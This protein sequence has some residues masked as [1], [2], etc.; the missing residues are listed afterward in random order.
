MKQN[1][2][3]SSTLGIIGFVIAMAFTVFAV[4]YN[5]SQAQP[6]KRQFKIE[7]KIMKKH[8][9]KFADFKRAYN[10]AKKIGDDSHDD[11]ELEKLDGITIR[12]NSKLYLVNIDDTPSAMRMGVV[13]YELIKVDY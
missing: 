9:N 3:F 10:I 11:T 4:H 7:Y 5:N 2:D 12:K 8:G 1:K 6:L 13:N